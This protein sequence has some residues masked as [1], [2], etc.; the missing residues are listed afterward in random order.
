[1]ALAIAAGMIQAGNQRLMIPMVPIAI[2]PMPSS[3]AIFLAPSSFVS[4]MV[5]A[6]K[7]GLKNCL[8]AGCLRPEDEPFADEGQE[9]GACGKKF[10]EDRDGGHDQHQKCDHQIIHEIPLCLTRR[11]PGMPGEGSHGG[12]MAINRRP[13]QAERGGHS[14][15][16]R[17]ARLHAV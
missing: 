16:W 2:L 1:M 11:P 15:P 3:V 13:P 8:R 12:G 10:E 6:V 7:S 5:S 14:G 9:G 17:N 4:K